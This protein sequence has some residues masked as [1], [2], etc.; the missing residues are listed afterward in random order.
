MRAIYSNATKSYINK[1]HKHVYLLISNK[2]R[3]DYFCNGQNIEELS[4]KYN[5]TADR[6]RKVVN[7]KNWKYQNI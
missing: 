3:F 1:Y 4:V 6:I 2:I 7:F 5:L